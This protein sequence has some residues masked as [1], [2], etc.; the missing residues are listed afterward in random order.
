MLAKWVVMAFNQY[1]FFNWTFQAP[2]VFC[3]KYYLSCSPP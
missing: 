1:L 3:F 2:F